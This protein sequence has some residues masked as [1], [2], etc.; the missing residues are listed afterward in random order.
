LKSCELY[1]KKI[2]A[3]ESPERAAAILGDEISSLV[4]TNCRIR[5]LCRAVLLV[6]FPAYFS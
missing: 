4:V 2:E 5:K 6:P 3:A 1:S